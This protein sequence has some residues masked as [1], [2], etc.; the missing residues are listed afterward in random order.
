MAD[1]NVV[2]IEGNIVWE[3]VYIENEGR[4]PITLMRIAC[5]RRRLDR[6]TGEW[7][8]APRYFNLIVKGDRAKE[9][10][11]TFVKGEKVLV[12]GY[13]DWYEKGEGDEHREFVTIVV[14]N[15]DDG[16]T[17]LCKPG[18]QGNAPSS[19]QDS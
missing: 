4:V 1:R 10:A 15:T 11:T 2:A 16:I 17:S 13:L 19:N 12:N 9:V 8:D 5:N 3:P 7:K 6:T 18:K 14:R